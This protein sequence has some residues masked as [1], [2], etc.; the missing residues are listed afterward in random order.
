MTTSVKIYPCPKC[1][2]GIEIESVNCG[3]FRHIEELSTK[4]Q[5]PHASQEKCE[6]GVANGA[7]LGC[8]AAFK[9]VPKADGELELVLCG[10]DT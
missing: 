2:G 4:A 8:G 5:D 6:K 7:V 9:V 10:Y 3:I 1:Q